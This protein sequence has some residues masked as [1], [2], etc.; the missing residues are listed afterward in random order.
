MSD[1]S[2][3]K[4][5]IEKQN[6]TFD[7]YK[8]VNDERLEHVANGNEA[9][10]NEAAAKLE[11]IDG[12]LNGV[13]KS[14]QEAEAERKAMQDRIEELE[15]EKSLPGAD[16]R[17]RLREEHTKA[18][19]DWVRKP[20]DDARKAA[21]HD[22]QRKAFEQKDVTIGTNAA[23]GFAVPE[24]IAREIE[25]LEL[26]FSPVRDLVKVVN[27]GTSDYKELVSIHPG[28]AAAAGWVG[29]TGTRSA[30]ST[31]NLREKAPTH[32]EVYAYPQVSEW[33]LDDI[34]FDVGNWITETVAEAFAILEGQAVISGN[35]T[36]K[37]TGM[38]NTAPVSTSDEASPLRDADAY[39][40][41]PIQNA[42]SPLV[43][44]FD[45]LIHTIYTLN[46]RYRTGSSW[47][48]NS[49]TTSTVRQ[50]KD[51]N[52]NYLWQPNNQA[53]QPATLL[54]FPVAT[55]EDMDDVADN[56]LPIAFGNF[57]RAYV[58]ANRVGMRMTQENVTNP[59]YVR[60]YI[61]RREG[62]IV[63]N[64]DAVKFVKVSET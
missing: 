9:A 19:D 23:G 52:N 54:G 36:N 49:L 17:E 35:G 37:P 34:F 24:Q 40:Y 26:K 62:G 50:L 13:S 10:A 7:E 42:A 25:R 33:S 6:R 11:K 1:L 29:E 59:G 27:V 8:K 4:E 41:V 15:A 31:P 55:W 64:N 48:M 32:G 53:G 58:L 56:A 63:L 60:F 38:T 46:S 21:L 47:V 12:D 18:F 14:L 30:T 5:L 45:T 3:I 28:A 57:R 44:N 22:V 39:Q 20:D 43:L 51:A 16:M 2:Q 61:R